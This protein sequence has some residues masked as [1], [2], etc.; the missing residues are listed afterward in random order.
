MSIPGD[1]WESWVSVVIRSWKY[2]FFRIDL[3]LRQMQESKPFAREATHLPDNAYHDY[4]QIWVR[5]RLEECLVF[6]V[7]SN[8]V[9][10]LLPF[11]EARS[12]ALKLLELSVLFLVAY[13]ITRWHV[14]ARRAGARC[15]LPD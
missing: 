6:F 12:P 1:G 9:L 13:T 10:F 11:G 7:T 3:S 5:I 4:D 14:M 2:V 8:A 15:R